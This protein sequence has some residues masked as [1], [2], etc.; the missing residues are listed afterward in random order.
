VTDVAEEQEERK[1][2][3]IEREYADERIA[4][5]WEPRYCI[6]VAACLMEQPRVFN[7]MRRPWIDLTQ[8]EADDIAQAVLGCPTGAL[9]FRRLDGGEQEAPPA[10][11][12]VQPRRNGPL[13]VRGNVRIIDQNE[14]VVR[15]DT[16]V[17]LCRCGQSRNKPFCDGTHRAIGFEAD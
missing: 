16:R 7:A 13:F 14:N 4:V 8:A 10:E 11:T 17:A 5:T 15:E 3:G 12:T 1:K 6:H 2:P 9:H